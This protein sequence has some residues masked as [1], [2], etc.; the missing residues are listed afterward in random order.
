M[1]SI[2]D[3]IVRG[4]TPSTST[5]SGGFW[6]TLNKWS[7]AAN[8]WINDTFFTVDNS[9]SGKV[10]QVKS[11][12]QLANEDVGGS[13]YPDR[14]GYDKAKNLAA[15]TPVAG[16][17]VSLEGA[18]NTSNDTTS[19]LLDGAFLAA[20]ASPAIVPIA[21]QGAKNVKSVTAFKPFT[22]RNFRYNLGQLT[23]NIPANSQAHHV[24]PK[25]FVEKFGTKINI[26][27]PKYGVW[28]EKTS[29]LQNAIEYNAEWR[30]FLRQDRTLT[31]ILN[32]GRE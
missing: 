8:E 25:E 16:A 31:E 13:L 12:R 27:D 9:N 18:T 5:S 11:Q 32:F 26:H 29:H 4:Q 22:E 7:Q 30:K 28:W 24:F 2:P 6:N 21:K 20:G 19:R 15:M 17:I 23:G 1:Y 10:A 3:E 14:G